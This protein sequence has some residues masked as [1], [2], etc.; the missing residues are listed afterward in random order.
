MKNDTPSALSKLGYKVLHNIDFA[1]AGLC[2]VFALSSRPF[3]MSIYEKPLANAKERYEQMHHQADSIYRA[4]TGKG[5]A[6]DAALSSYIY[7]RGEGKEKEAERNFSYEFHGARA[8]F[9]RAQSSTEF[10]SIY[11]Y[12]TGGMFAALGVTMAAHGISERRR[13]SKKQPGGTAP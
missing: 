1:V 10:A 6:A 4:E 3:S 8:M 7:H 12:V 9:N 13:S 11:G 2:L 5:P